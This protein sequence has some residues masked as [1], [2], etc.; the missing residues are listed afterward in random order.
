MNIDRS[1][2]RPTG[3]YTPSI[4]RLHLD[5]DAHIRFLLKGLGTLSRGFTSLDAS[6][7]WICYWILHSLD[8]MNA[9]PPQEVLERW[10]CLWTCFHR[11][12]SPRN[13]MQRTLYS[14]LD[15]LLLCQNE[16][17]GFGGGFGQLSHLATTYA[18]V[19]AIAII[20]LQRG[21]DA[22]RR[23]VSCLPDLEDIQRLNY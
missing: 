3:Q 17:G 13:L 6:K 5:R 1:R 10:V 21:F 8:L 12:R 23:F 22:I 15:T 4:F 2:G 20:G 7:P 14:V 18:A 11:L 19:N 9:L 16:T